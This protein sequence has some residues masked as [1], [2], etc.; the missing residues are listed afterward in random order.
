[1]ADIA[2][3]LIG[4]GIADLAIVDDDIDSD[5][6]LSTAVLLSLHLDERADDAAVGIDPDDQRGWWGD[7]FAEIIDDSQGSQLW[8]L[9]RSTI[10]PN[11]S[12]ETDANIQD[13]LSWMIA[14][15]I[16]SEIIAEST[17]T[18]DGLEY[19]V[20]ITRLSGDAL[21]FKYAN[22]WDPGGY[23]AF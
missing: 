5:S 12:A 21:P 22:T 23:D 20:T 6:G 3:R 11:L 8:R 2:I 17:V 4:N 13:A 9:E 7:E 18:A 1:M 16:A 10:T 19:T 14:D 15:K